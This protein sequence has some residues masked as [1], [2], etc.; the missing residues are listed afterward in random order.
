MPNAEKL[1][2][3][4]GKKGLSLKSVGSIQKGPGKIIFKNALTVAIAGSSEK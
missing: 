1:T 4:R 2:E 3:N